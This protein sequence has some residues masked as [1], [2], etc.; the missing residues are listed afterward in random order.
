MEGRALRAPACEEFRRRREAPPSIAS[1]ASP[2][3]L[4][5]NV[6][7]NEDVATADVAPLFASAFGAVR[8]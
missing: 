2:R 4:R 7:G 5:P 3:A 6:R 1:K 8:Q